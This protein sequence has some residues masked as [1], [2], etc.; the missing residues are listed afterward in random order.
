LIS[1]RSDWLSLYQPLFTGWRLLFVPAST[2]ARTEHGTPW[3][4]ALLALALALGAE[5]LRR[6]YGYS[7]Q[8]GSP[9][10][11]PNRS[12]LAVIACLFLIGLFP[13]E[14]AIGLILWAG[15]GL[16]WGEVAGSWPPLP[17]SLRQWGAL[18]A[19][20]F[21]GWIGLA[22]PGSWIMALVLVPLFLFQVRGSR[23][24]GEESRQ[25]T[26]SNGFRC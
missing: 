23:R 24:S 2:L 3:L 20:F 13:Q 18:T 11:S 22:G 1:G 19:G 14:G 15:I 16:A 6:E 17:F 5:W 25:A 10:S 26:K 21:L 8:D 9:T 7:R 4:M 12:V